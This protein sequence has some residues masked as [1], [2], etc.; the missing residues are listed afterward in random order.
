[1]WWI[2]MMEFYSPIKKKEV[3]S[4]SGKSMELEIIC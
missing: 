2:Y 4:F 1:M 3:T